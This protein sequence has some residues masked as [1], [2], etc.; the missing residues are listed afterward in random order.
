VR[1]VKP[2]GTTAAYRRHY[3]HG[4]KPCE[5]CKKA[6][7]I[8]RADRDRTARNEEVRL[9]YRALREAGLSSA[10]ADVYK[11]R[12]SVTV[13]EAVRLS[14]ERHAAQARRLPRGS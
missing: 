7:A 1:R 3:R 14:R 8:V 9:R 10:D 12:K 5:S 4:G 6:N 13:E 2:C 11:W